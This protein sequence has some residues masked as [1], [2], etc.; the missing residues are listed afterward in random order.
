MRAWAPILALAFSFAA[1]A[2]PAAE[3]WP[4]KPVR[5][6]VPFATGSSSDS[7]ARLLAERLG[8]R[9]KQ[10]F[11]VDNRAGAGG[12]TGV[13]A[14]AQS[15]A[16]GY[17]LLLTTSS[18]LVINPA[19]DKHL[20]YDVK[21]DFAPVAIIGTLPLMLVARPDFPAKTLPELIGYAKKNPG[22]LAYATNGVGS[23]SHLS[24]ELF[25]QLAGLDINH[26][27]YKGPAQA[28]TDV[29]GGNVQLMFDS[30]TSGAELVRSGKL[31]AYGMSSKAPDA[32]MPGVQPLASQ[33]VAELHGFDVLAWAGLLAPAATP[34]PVLARLTEA[35]R[36]ALAD[37]EFRKQMTLRAT[38]PATPQQAGEM[39]AWMQQESARWAALI[40]SANLKLE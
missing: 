34:Q 38:Q 8:V 10:A 23:Y 20:R 40:K 22:K 19:F 5:I 1:A 14:V 18:P 30:V 25:K 24:M 39:A 17:T 32:L 11:I 36:Q 35:T 13:A 28:E 9:F 7:I 26:V 29:I 4:T 15:P 27:P 33:G 6:V 16:D 12:T 21:R 3:T 37:P 2:Q 31:H